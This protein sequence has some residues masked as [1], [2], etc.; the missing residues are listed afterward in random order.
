MIAF[1][2]GSIFGFLIGVVITSVL[3]DFQRWGD[4]E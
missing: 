4:G 2:A 1:F 3:R